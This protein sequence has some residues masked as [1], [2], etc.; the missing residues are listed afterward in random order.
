MGI[1]DGYNTMPTE[2]IIGT[3]DND[4]EFASTN[5]V[6]NA[7]GSVLERLEKIQQQVGA[8]DGADNPIGANDADNGFV[9]SAVVANADGS[10]LERIE[11]LQGELGA[12]VGAS[13]SADIAAI[14]TQTDEIGS[15]TGASISADIAAVQTEVDKLGTPAGASISADVAAIK[16]E[17]VLIKAKTDLIPSDP[18][19]QS[20][21]ESAITAAHAITDGLIVDEGYLINKEITYDGSASYTAFTVT[22]LVLAKV[23]GYITTPLTNSATPTSVGTASSAAGLIAATA[24]EAMQTANQVWVDNAPSKFEAFPTAYSIIG[25]GEDIVVVGDTDLSAGVVTLYCLWKPISDDGNVV[26]T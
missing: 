21:V 10:I 5:V 19:D 8:V 4:N 2:Y 22:G 16:A 20:D 24:G 23:F 17:T 12:S 13:I 18:A 1:P 26:A 3:D 25:N 14:K 7:D 9:S 11:Y 15:A 6:A